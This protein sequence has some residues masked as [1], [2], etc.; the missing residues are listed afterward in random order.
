MCQAAYQNGAIVEILTAQG[1]RCLLNLLG[2]GSLKY[3]KALGSVT[4]AYD[5]TSK[6]YIFLMD[7]SSNCKLQFP[8]DE[9]QSLALIQP[10]LVLQIYLI[11]G[12]PFTLELTVLDSSRVTLKN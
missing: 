2:G 8:K 9:K 4:K 6:G 7:S 10:Y 12:K 5:K 1:T 11:K 3:A